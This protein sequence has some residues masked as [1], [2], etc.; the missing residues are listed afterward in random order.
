MTANLTT[1]QPQATD[2]VPAGDVQFVQYH[3]P[4]IRDGDFKVTV[5]QTVNA[6]SKQESIPASTAENPTFPPAKML[7]SVR[8][9]RFS[10]PEADIFSVFP[11]KGNLGDHSNVLPHIMLNRS[12]LP[13]ERDCLPKQAQ[14]NYTPWL[15]LLLF[16]EDESITISTLTL[17]ELMQTDPGVDFPTIALEKGQHASD[18]VTVI[19]VPKSLLEQVMPKTAKDLSLLAHVRRSSDDPLI[20]FERAV[21]NSNR[22]PTPGKTSTV[23]L[24]SLENRFSDN[25]FVYATG[26]NQKT[27]IRLVSLKHW[28]FA[29]LL[30]KHSFKGLL[31][32]LKQSG[33]EPMTLRVPKRSDATAEQYAQCGYILLPH[34]LRNG[35]QTGSWYHSPLTPI[36]E[37]SMATETVT[38]PTPASD[39]LLLFDSKEK[40]LDVSY[41]AAWELGRILSLNSKSF[42]TGLYKWKRAHKANL[43][44]AEQKLIHG[45]L[46]I[47]KHQTPAEESECPFPTNLGN[48]LAGL[49]LLKG[50]PFNY[51]APDQTMLPAESIRFFNIDSKWVECLLDGAFSIGRVLTSDTEMDARHTS[52]LLSFP[53]MSGFLLRSEVVSGWPGLLVEGSSLVVNNMDASLADNS[54]LPLLRMD[55]LS[56]S[57]L[58][59]VFAGTLKTVDIHLKPEALHFGVTLQNHGK[60]FIKKLR[61][62]DGNTITDPGTETALSISPVSLSNDRVIDISALAT[63]I[64]NKLPSGQQ[65][66]SMDSAKFA[67]E[68]IEG[69]DRVRYIYGK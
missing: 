51:L 49:A 43:K 20:Q 33:Q 22:L 31:I 62:P 44:L 46:P 15:A 64:Q 60:S 54:P 40:L 61:D 25:G 5:T 7:F 23:H 52:D 28:R 41:A 42:S 29:C 9:P 21:I 35:Q 17:G 14:T 32:H 1:E 4:Q 16:D 57:V 11:P 34:Y 38:L 69:V 48:W 63:E 19:D 24:V 12:T 59:C 58:I 68:M 50:I 39:P 26:D 55:R 37:S 2:P 66:T 45:Y 67:L 27:L 6:T 30:E 47:D 18:S 65:A 10:L 8:G 53:K 13:W 56:P 3:A 36:D